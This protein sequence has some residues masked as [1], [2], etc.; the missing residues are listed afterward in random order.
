MPKT[1]KIQKKCRCI[2]RCKNCHKYSKKKC[3]KKCLKKKCPCVKRTKRTRKN[4]LSKKR[5][6]KRVMKNIKRYKQKGCSKQRGG[7]T[8]AA[9]MGEIFT[10]YKLNTYDKDITRSNSTQNHIM[11]GGNI[12]NNFG[13]GKVLDVKNNVIDTFK[14]GVNTWNGDHSVESSDVT[15]PSKLMK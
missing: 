3:C 13:L 11:K 7:F 14:N 2:C 5:K 15:T 1:K 9:N 8:H 12:M 6:N 10:G 4:K